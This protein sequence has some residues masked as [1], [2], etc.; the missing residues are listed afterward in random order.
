MA[1]RS[2]SSRSYRKPVAGPFLA[3]LIVASFGLL[4]VGCKGPESV[5]ENQ[6]FVFTQENVD[7]AHQLAVSATS[8][9]TLTESGSSEPYLEPL[10]PSAS[11]ATTDT[12]VLDLSMVNTYNAIREGQGTTGKDTYRVTNE[13]LNLRDKAS[14]TAGN[15]ARLVYGDSVE[16]ISFT[17]AS[18]AQV[19]T[20]AGQTGY[21]S[22]RYIAKM[23]T[24]EELAGEKKKFDGQ[25]YVSY[26]FVNVRK[27]ASQGSDKIGEIPGQTILKP[28][29]IA[30][31][32]A[33]VTYNGMTG[34]V[35]TSYLSPFKP[36][37][38]VRQ[39]QYT[40]PVLHYQ[41]TNGQESDILKALETHVA[42]LKAQGKNFITFATFHDLLLQ[43][44]KQNT[45]VDTNDVIIAI[46]NV[47]PDNVHMISDALNT[48][49]VPATLFIQTKYVGLS[50]ITQKTLLTLIANGFDI[51]SG[52]HT[53]DDL[54]ALTN[55]QMDLE[56]KQSRKILEDMTG[57]P[58]FAV[59][60]PQGGSNDRVMQLASADG[61]LLGLGT[62]SDKTFTRD[63]LLNI[64]GIDIFPNMTADEV[65]T[66]VTLK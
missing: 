31:G 3:F 2:S 32:W 23:T 58:V 15:L 63:Q 41:M 54:R 24:D 21:V 52:T 30:N 59:A 62:G 13:F 38:I 16:L 22:V 61:Y 39:N 40:L 48:A 11:G 43:Q 8:G 64:P 36:N 26:G 53:G 20:A 7:Q 6:D 33:N 9:S 60:Y 27:E 42:A 65:T 49:A 10:D 46:T 17:N 50:G 51:E 66:L 12:A 56:L 35:A 57:K 19:K 47:T 29:S 44:Q 14:T 25:Y 1:H 18:W 4:F 5:S 55:A 45:Q 37:F 34:F 28:N